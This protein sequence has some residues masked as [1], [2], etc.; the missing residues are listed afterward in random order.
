MSKKYGGEKNIMNN[1]R[2]YPISLLDHCFNH[3]TVCDLVTHMA[4]YMK[5]NAEHPAY[6]EFKEILHQLIE[7]V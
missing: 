1:Y 2:A 5:N 3:E 7:K 6:R 4:E